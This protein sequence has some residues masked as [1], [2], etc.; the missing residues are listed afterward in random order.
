MMTAWARGCGTRSTDDPGRELWLSA[1]SVWE[2]GIKVGLGRLTLPAPL[3]DVVRRAVVAGRLRVLDR[4]LVAQ[5]QAEGL[6][7]ASVDARVR[8]YDVRTRW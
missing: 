2:I 8:L 7:L 6:V 1:A 4:M 5:A 3:R